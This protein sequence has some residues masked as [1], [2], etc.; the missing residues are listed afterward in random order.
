MRSICHYFAIL[1]WS[2]VVLVRPCGAEPAKP[3][4]QDMYNAAQAAFD[5]GDWATAITGFEKIVKPD[6]G[7][8]IGRSQAIIRARLAQ[9]YASKGDSE[10][11]IFSANVALKGLGP[12]DALER[13]NM[14][15]AMADAKRYE[16][17]MGEAVSYYEKALS[18]AETLKSAGLKKAALFGKVFALGTVDPAQA[19]TIL[20]TLTEDH[21]DKSPA[22]NLRAA[23]LQMLIGRAQLNLG[24]PRAALKSLKQAGLLTGGMTTL[25][26]NHFQQSIRGDAAIAAQLLKD[27]EATHEY[28]TY[29]GAGHLPSENWTSGIGAPPVCG[30][31]GDLKPDDVAVVEFSI[32][33]DGHVIGALPIYA[34]RPGEVGST[35]AKAVRRWHWNPAKLKNIEK[36]WRDAIRLELRCV[37]RPQQAGLQAKSEEEMVRWISEKGADADTG[38]L[39]KRGYV[40]DTDPRLTSDGIT[41]II[42]LYVTLA[43]GSLAE[44]KDLPKYMV[45]FQSAL[46]KAKAPTDALALAALFKAQLSGYSVTKV[47]NMVNTFA[48]SHPTARATQWLALE[49]GLLLERKRALDLAIEQYGKVVAAPIDQLDANDPVRTVATLH[50]AALKKR[51]GDAAGAEQI[52]AASGLSKA[53][54]SLVDVRPVAT[55]ASISDSIF[56]QEALRWGFDGY[57]RESFD[58]NAQGNV[59]NVRTVVAYPP[60]VFG[61]ATEK[62]VGKFR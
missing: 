1:C 60:F 41:S 30:A 27:T 54:C 25:R 57:V 33:D 16:A 2:A 10:P 50:L 45:R 40:S 3:S 49:Y 61:P 36:F 12:D 46:E 51:A 38:M 43:N 6:T 55:N 52:V 32:A 35:F 26:I 59:E 39:I 42:P 58:I 11:A 4:V 5:Q 29:T 18:D 48:T 9:A 23:V 47:A 44:N 14:W 24:N 8:P 62:A 21:T 19:V 15:L 53:Q 28:L 31:E 56:P 22:G 17:S 37:K 7:A 34:N 13:A 20:T